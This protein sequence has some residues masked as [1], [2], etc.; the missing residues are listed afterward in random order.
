MGAPCINEV[1]NLRND[2]AT[3]LSNRWEQV[4][5]RHLRALE[6]TRLMEKIL[7]KSEK[8]REVVEEIDRRTTS[9]L[10][11]HLP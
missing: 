6:N 9:I 5:A 8:M 7:Y 3:I 10:G 2:I 1:T 11:Y 4:D